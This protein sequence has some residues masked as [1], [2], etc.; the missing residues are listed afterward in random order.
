[1]PINVNFWCTKKKKKMPINVRT[2]I[3]NCT[4]P[5]GG[6]EEINCKSLKQLIKNWSVKKRGTKKQYVFFH[7]MF[8]R[9]NGKDRSMI[10]E[11]YIMDTFKCWDHGINVSSAFDASV[12]SSVSDLRNHLKS[13]SRTRRNLSKIQKQCPSKYK[14][15]VISEN[16]YR[17]VPLE[18]AFYS[19]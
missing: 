17:K 14:E 9:D 7:Y 8:C 1:M 6:D 18:Q 2:C 19:L 15:K 12:D 11:T 3:K 5:M 10:C 4:G 16:K 13:R